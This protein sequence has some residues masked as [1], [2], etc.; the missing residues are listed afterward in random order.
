[1]G[2]KI[3]QIA[4]NADGVFALCNDGSVFGLSNGGWRQLPAVPQSEEATGHADAG[5]HAQIADLAIQLDLSPAER[6]ALEAKI[7]SRTVMRR[8][9]T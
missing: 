4:A 1:M 9:E 7:L 2:R 5:I 6:A 8:K 3:L